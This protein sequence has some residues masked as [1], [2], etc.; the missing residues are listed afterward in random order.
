MVQ[1]VAVRPIFEERIR[2]KRYK[3]VGL[4]REAWWRQYV[5]RSNLGQPWQKSCGDQIGGGDGKIETRSRI[6]GN[7]EKQSR[8][9]GC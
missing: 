4:M 6:Q 1:W 8:T 2:E 3:G 7:T 5:C 9:L